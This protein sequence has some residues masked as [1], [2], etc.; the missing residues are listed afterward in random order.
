MVDF[1]LTV[2]DMVLILLVVVVPTLLLLEITSWLEYSLTQMSLAFVCQQAFVTSCLI[3]ATTMEQLKE[4][5]AAVELTLS[6]DVMAEINAI[7]NQY[8]DPAP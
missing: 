3:G 7:H 2:W 8:P 6:E 1:D 4:N 5:I